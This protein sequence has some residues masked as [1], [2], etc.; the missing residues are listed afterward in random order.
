MVQTYRNYPKPK[1]S[2]KSDS[3]SHTQAL[4]KIYYSFTSY[5]K[6]GSIS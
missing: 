1:K 3:L 5:L 2:L 6:L 4:E